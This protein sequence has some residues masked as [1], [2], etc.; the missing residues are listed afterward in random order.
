[1]IHFAYFLHFRAQ[2]Y[3]KIKKQ[4]NEKGK[5]MYD[6]PLFGFFYK[7]RHKKYNYQLS[8]HLSYLMMYFTFEASRGLASGCSSG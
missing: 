2:R 6:T 7:I 5:M 3:N 8:H 1:M 4:T